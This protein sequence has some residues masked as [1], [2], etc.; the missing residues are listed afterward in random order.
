[1]KTPPYHSG[2]VPRFSWSSSLEKFPLNTFI[3]NPNDR[4]PPLF[5]TQIQ[6]PFFSGQIELE[7][8][9]TDFSEKRNIRG[10]RFE[11]EDRIVR[12]T[13]YRFLTTD[14]IFF[15][16]IPENKIAKKIMSDMCVKR[17]IK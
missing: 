3:K 12:K 10:R 16:P 11:E 13:N 6:P 14:F 2:N 9:L 17:G 8:F 5:L 15:A 7:C 1:M 4:N